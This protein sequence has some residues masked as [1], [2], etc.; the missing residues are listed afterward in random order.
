MNEITIRQWYD[1]FKSGE[2][3]VEVRIVD[4]AYKRTYSGYFTDVNTLLNEIR[5]YD[6]CN[7]YFTLNAINPA[8]YDREQHDRIVT[9]PKSTTSDND[10]VGR[11]WILI[12]I[13]TKKPSDTNSTDEEKEMAKEVVNNVFKFLRDEGFEKPV[14]CDS[15]NGFHLLYKIAMKNSNENTTIC[16]EF[17]QVLDMLFSNPNVEIDCT[18]HN[19]SRVCKL[20]GTFSRK[21]S[22]T[23]KRPQRE[24]KILRIPD[25][26]KITPNEYFAKVAAMLPKPE[27]PSKSNYYSNE[28]FDL[29]AFLNKHHIAV[30]NIVRTSSFTKYIL[31]ECPFNSSHRAPDSAI[32]EMSNGGLGFKCL[33]SSCSQYTWKDFR[34]KFEPDAYDHKEYQRHEH[35]MQYYSSQKKEPFVPKKEDSAKGKKWLAMTDVQ[36]VDMSKLVAI[37]TGYKELDKKIIGLLMGDVTVLSGLSGCVDCDT[38]YF[39]GTEWKKISDYSYGDKVLQY[40]KD[41]SAELVYPTDYIKKQCDYLSLIK[42]KYGVNQCVSDEHR[43]VYQTSKKNLAIKTF[44]ELKEQHAGSKHGFIGKFYTTFN[45]SGKGIPL[46]EFEIRLMCAIIC[47]GH[48]CNL[49][50]DKSTCRIN[51]KKERKKQRLEWI[52]G[53]LNMP[54]DKHQWNPKDLGYNSYLVKAPRIEKEFSNFWYD[55]NKEQMAIICDEI[56]NWDGYITPKRKNFS[57]IS[58]KTIDFIQFCFACCG[59]RS[60]ISIDDRLGQKHYKNICYSLTI[61]KR[62][63]VS[64]FASNNPKKEFPIYK[65]KDGYKYCFSVPSGMLVLRREG[66]INI[67]GNSGKSSWIDCVVLNAVQRGYKVGI[68]SGELQDFRFQSWI[69][70]I[71][72][73]KNYVCKKEG[74]E[75]YYYA[76]KNISNQINKWLE[77]KL[78]LYNNNY[79]SKWQQLFADIKTLVENEG[80]QLVVLDNLMAL[81][82]DSYD[83][84][85][86]TQQ[87]RF[88]NDLKEYAKAKN[89]HVILVCH[90]RKEGG[91]LRKESISGT[92]DLTNLADS[93]I[94]IHRIGK[95]FEQR[96]GEFFGKDKVLPYLKYNSAI[97]VC[98]NRSMGVIDLLVGMYYEVESRRLKNEISEN[99]VYGWQ[100]QPA[101]LTFEPTPESDVSDL[102]DIYDNMSNQLPFGSELQELPF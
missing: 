76:P 54:I 74:Y 77:G 79:G 84:D 52:L 30:R 82:I 49:Y 43:I 70:Q 75:N 3:L 95:D 72:A 21:G 71:A 31:D 67:T 7:I 61:T 23:K 41:G 34:L 29:E 59:Y 53:K 8:C 68:W 18:T 55:C 10:I 69:D 90:P 83:G 36:Y 11:D 99:I 92:A 19:A 57:S 50:K 73:G 28:K 20:Y 101:Q 88:I 56:L 33:H 35:K 14:V 37:P 44:A 102:Q 48:F 66:R 97:E 17:L 87:T 63:M 89:I 9:K 42:S 47:D 39:N 81:Q 4:N 80:T 5:K 6:N 32:F 98:K 86:Y 16:K 27:Q 64:I 93:V 78:F 46:S 24:S 65:T 96:A 26:I 15:G 1:T 38:E 45:Y 13:D 91:F 58:K 25:E 100:E 60:T 40:N 12:D 2:E 62:N 22:N 85:K 51:L 94:I